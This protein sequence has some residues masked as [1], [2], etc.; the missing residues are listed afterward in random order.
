M[1]PLKRKAS[2]RKPS[3]RS[4]RLEARFV[5]FETERRRTRSAQELFAV[6]A[7]FY[8]AAEH[9]LAGFDHLLVDGKALAHAPDGELDARCRELGVRPLMEFFSQDPEATAELIANSG[10]DPAA[11]NIP[12]EQWF[13]PSEGLATVQALLNAP[14]ALPG[15]AAAVAEDLRGCER[16]LIHLLSER[17]RWH[18]AI[19]F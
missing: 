14:A 7:A 11:V 12:A 6:G 5:L 15:S 1:L 9:E 19:D 8:I 17:V 13:D 10:G 16:V 4:G 18:L 3:G 2:P